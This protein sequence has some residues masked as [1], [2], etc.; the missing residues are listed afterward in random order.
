M[1]E[2]G[3]V[4]PV[5]GQVELLD[6]GIDAFAERGALQTAIA[7]EIAVFGDAQEDDAV[8]GALD[9]VVELAL[10]Q[11]PVDETRLLVQMLGQ[12]NAPGFHIT[13]KGFVNAQHAFGGRLQQVA[14]PALAHGSGDSVSCSRSH[15]SRY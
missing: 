7:F 4:A 3:V 1:E 13:Q 8:D 6:L 12:V 5:G 10:V 15:S 9:Q 14:V 2:A 11:R